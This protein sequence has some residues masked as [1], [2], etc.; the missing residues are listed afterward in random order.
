MSS[1]DV[2]ELARRIAVASRIRTLADKLERDT[3]IEL[4]DAL[5]GRGSVAAVDPGSGAEIGLVTI[6]KASPGKTLVNVD[7]DTVAVWLAEH[8]PEYVQTKPVMHEWAR[9]EL[10]RLAEQ[11]EAPVGPGGEVDLPGVAVTFTDPRP[12]APSFRAA[13]DADVVIAEMVATGHLTLPT[14]LALDGATDDE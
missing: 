9:A 8:Y 14:L 2:A 13:P 1:N 7:D 11:A 5:A 4:R 3:K 6:P 12:G 10:V